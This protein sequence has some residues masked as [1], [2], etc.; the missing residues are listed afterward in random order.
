MPQECNLP[1]IMATAIFPQEEFILHPW[2]EAIPTLIK[3]FKSAE[4]LSTV[5][6]VLGG[7]TRREQITPRLTKR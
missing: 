6:K 4:L 3:P 1:V 5:I 7:A 2:L